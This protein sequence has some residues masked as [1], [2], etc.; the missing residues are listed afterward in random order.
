MYLFPL[1]A[2]H[3]AFTGWTHTLFE[4]VIESMGVSA[5]AMLFQILIVLL[6]LAPE[7]VKVYWESNAEGDN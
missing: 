4:A 5:F 1:W 6:Y 2:A 7:H 3:N